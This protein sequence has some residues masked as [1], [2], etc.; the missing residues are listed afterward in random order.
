MLESLS[1]EKHYSFWARLVATKK[2]RWYKKTS[3][4]QRLTTIRLQYMS[5]VLTDALAYHTLVLMLNCKKS[6]I[7]CAQ[8]ETYF[9]DSNQPF[10]SLSVFKFRWKRSNRIKLYFVVS[11]SVSLNF[12]YV[13]HLKVKL[14]ASI[15]IL[16]LI[17]NV[18]WTENYSK[19][20]VKI[21]VMTTE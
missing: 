16:T 5:Y 20:L 12:E 1:R 19:S 17:K 2:I 8:V 15:L 9:I 21:I 4:R 13:L 6:F 7:V 11:W 14:G 10:I 18:Y 3:L